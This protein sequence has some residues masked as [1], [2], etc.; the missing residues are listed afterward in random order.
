MKKVFLPILLAF[1]A[2]AV[3]V[4]VSAITNWEVSVFTLSSP[5]FI[6][7]ALA[8]IGNIFIKKRITVIIASIVLF[9]AGIAFMIA[10]S[11][12]RPT[13]DADRT[14][15]E[16]LS[17][18]RA[19]VLEGIPV[20]VDRTLRGVLSDI[21]TLLI[22][23]GSMMFGNIIRRPSV[24]KWLG[25]LGIAIFGFT[26]LIASIIPVGHSVGFGLLLLAIALIYIAL[27]WSIV[28]IYNIRHTAHKTA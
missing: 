9:A 26:A 1:C 12:V 13:L 24:P 4:F 17:V 10:Y 3:T 6:A 15:S 23:T 16:V 14:L 19:A 21:S 7:A 5:V 11:T 27:Y 25:V 18:L 22:L 2:V 8:F 20:Q 28:C